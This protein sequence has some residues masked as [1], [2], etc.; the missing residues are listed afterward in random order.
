MNYAVIGF[1]IRGTYY[2]WCLTKH[3]AKLIGVCDSRQERLDLAKKSYGVKEENLFSSVEE[4]FHREKMCELCIIATH[5]ETHYEIAIQALQKGYDLLLEKPIATKIE[6]CEEI[7][8]LAQKL[9]R[10]VFVCHILRYAPFFMTLK[11]ELASGK[12]GKVST[13]NLTENVAYWHQAHSYVRGTWRKAEDS[14][15]MIVAKCCHDLDI[16]AWLIDKDCRYVSSM[17]SLHLFKKENMPQGAADRCIACKYVD[18]CPYSAVNIYIKDRFEK[19]KVN[20]PCNVL[21]INPTRE[22]LMEA[23]ENGPYGK[24][25]FACDNDVVDH[26]VVNME[27]DE[28]ITAH[29]TM[30]AFSQDSY[31]EI[32]VHCEYGEIYGNMMDNR[33]HCNIF[34][35]ESKVLD[36]NSL[37][38]EGIMAGHGGGDERLI[39]DIVN[40]YENK[41]S[42]GLTSIEKSLASHRIAFISEQSRLQHGERLA[43]CPKQK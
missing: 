3:D 26:Q 36:L 42:E 38:V 34:G 13:V 8:A 24:C 12:Y 5:D 7:C 11:K 17:G 15:P 14:T 35:K 6:H 22:S 31:R 27:F 29:L 9:G 16:L 20:W 2:S 10:R 43:V 40:V 4:F 21:A 28:G 18:D 19:G 37:G 23:I 25:V 30:T 41:K 33:L 39:E 32:H 1:G